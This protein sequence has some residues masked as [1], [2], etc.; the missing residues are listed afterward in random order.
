[1][2]IITVV[3]GKLN[4]NTYIVTTEKGNAVIIDPSLDYEKIQKALDDSGAALKFIIFTHGH[5]DHTASASTLAEKTG[6]KLVINSRDAEML[7]DFKKSLSSI[8]TNSPKES[9]ADITVEDEDT[10]TLDELTF[11]F[12]ST[13]GHSKGSMIIF[14]KDV[15]FTGDT[16]LEGT[17][18][19]TDLY[20][21]D[22]SLMI[23]S[24]RKLASVE[25]DYT[26]LC[27]HGEPSTLEREKHI[28]P[29]FIE[30]A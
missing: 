24:V 3:S 30:Y 20:G 22:E 4:N 16:V 12:M 19:R 15:M 10:L 8:F 2:K 6:A 14:C 28:N 21:S 11:R 18:G 29:Y 25:G 23:Q 26:L 13:P 17:V 27:G 5:Y 7:Y 9:H 1:M